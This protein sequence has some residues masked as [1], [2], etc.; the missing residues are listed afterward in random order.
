MDGVEELERAWRMI[1]LNDFKSVG[2]IRVH[3]FHSLFLLY[4]EPRY[5]RAKMGITPLRDSP[6]HGGNRMDD[7]CAD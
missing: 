4:N 5:H 3:C 6:Y 7:R 1:P 2:L